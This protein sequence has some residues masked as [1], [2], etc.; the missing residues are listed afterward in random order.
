[1]PN[2]ENPPASSN[3]CQS[4]LDRPFLK[5]HLPESAVVLR[6]LRSFCRSRICASSSRCFACNN[7]FSLSVIEHPPLVLKIGLIDFDVIPNILPFGI[8]LFL[9][10]F[11]IAKMPPFGIAVIPNEGD[12]S[13]RSCPQSPKPPKDSRHP[14][15]AML[16]RRL[17]A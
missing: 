1:M 16:L 8:T 6:A 9:K 13:I 14:Q 7:F 10:I 11:V 2:T 4:Q 5:S 15:R 12:C 3:P 17:A